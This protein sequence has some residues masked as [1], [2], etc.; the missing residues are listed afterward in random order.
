[1]YNI[2][3][4]KQICAELTGLYVAKIADY[5]DSIHKS[6]EKYGLD[7]EAILCRL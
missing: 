1:M 7:M 4:H 6:F 5:E 2:E 3:K